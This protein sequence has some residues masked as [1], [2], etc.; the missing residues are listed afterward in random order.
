MIYF[1]ADKSR[2]I[3]SP[4]S[5]LSILAVTTWIGFS[6]TLGCSCSQEDPA[7]QA[8]ENMFDLG[9]A[10]PGQT[11]EADAQA[12][13]DHTEDDP[14]ESEDRKRNDPDEAATGDIVPAEDN[15]DPNFNKKGDKQSQN[16]PDT[17]PPGPPADEPI[18]GEDAEA[19]PDFGSIDIRTVTD[20]Q[21]AAEIARHLMKQAHSLADDGNAV[22][23]YNK[24]IDVLDLV[25]PHAEQHPDCQQLRIEAQTLSKNL[26]GLINQPAPDAGEPIKIR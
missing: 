23:A 21:Q 6:F 10:E 7:Y 24:A 26:E 9:A 1:G 17:K 4:W 19:V 8:I 3:E 5:R 11:E 2:S 14:A 18:Q 25:Y 22:K 20:P 13:D 12:E 16:P 15:P